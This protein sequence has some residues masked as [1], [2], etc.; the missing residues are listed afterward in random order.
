[1]KALIALAGLL[2]F[3][4]SSL[5][6]ASVRTESICP[7]EPEESCRWQVN[8]AGV[9]RTGRDT[10]QV[11]WEKSIVSRHRQSPSGQTLRC[12]LDRDFNPQAG[13]YIRVFFV[14][15]KDFCDPTTRDPAECGVSFQL[16]DPTDLQTASGFDVT[17]PN[18]KRLAK[19][20]HYST[21]SLRCGDF[22]NNQFDQFSWDTTVGWKQTP[23][24]PVTYSRNK[25]PIRR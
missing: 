1:V 7:N 8:V 9:R 5:M 22:I 2:V 11:R 17:A 20:E 24:G 19:V 13:G 4:S 10:V 3:S 16:T 23:S 12:N 15:E 14:G 18:T 25:R 21:L 6:A